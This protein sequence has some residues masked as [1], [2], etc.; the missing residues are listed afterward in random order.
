MGTQCG[1]AVMQTLAAPQGNKLVYTKALEGAECYQTSFS[2]FSS[3]AKDYDIRIE[4]KK[5]GAGV[6]ITGDRPLSRFGYWS[7]RT[8]MA[9]EPYVDINIEPGQE[10]TWKITYDYYTT[11]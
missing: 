3:D 6:H 9:A 4:N 11:P 5:V 2:G 10:F 7:I 8:V 1:Q